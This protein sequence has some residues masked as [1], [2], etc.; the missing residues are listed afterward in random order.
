VN[1]SS[2]N[3]WPSQNLQRHTVVGGFEPIT[4]YWLLFREKTVDVLIGYFRKR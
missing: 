2:K 3:E 1:L 4:N